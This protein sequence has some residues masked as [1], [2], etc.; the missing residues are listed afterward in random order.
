MQVWMNNFKKQFKIFL[1]NMKLFRQKW[2]HQIHQRDPKMTIIYPTSSLREYLKL[3]NKIWIRDLKKLKRLR[4]KIWWKDWRVW[5]LDRY[6]NNPLTTNNLLKFHKIWLRELKNLKIW[7]KI[8]NK[9]N[10]VPIKHKTF[11]K[12]FKE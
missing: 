3:K 7:L 12:L 8:S 11:K 10:K 9:T 4:L 1:K 2:W 6:N 5:N